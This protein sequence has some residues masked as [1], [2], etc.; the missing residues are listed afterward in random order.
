MKIVADTN[1]LVTNRRSFL[2]GTRNPPRFVTKLSDLLFSTSLLPGTSRFDGGIRIS[3]WLV[4][5]LL[6]FCTDAV[7]G[8]DA[9]FCSICD[10]LDAIEIVESGGDSDAVGDNGKAIGAYQIW[11]I[12][13]DDVNRILGE[14]RYS[15]NDRYSRAKSRTMTK[16]YI[17]HYATEKRLKRTPTLEDMA[18]MFCAGPDGY[19]QLNEPKV[20][21]YIKKIKKQLTNSNKK[22]VPNNIGKK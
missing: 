9:H 4:L 7:S 15:Y 11:K 10:L 12:Y 17:G 22:N 21:E 20:K 8:K 3:S 18:A 19:R 16:I 14:Q 6:F 1:I 2:F 13:V 5:F